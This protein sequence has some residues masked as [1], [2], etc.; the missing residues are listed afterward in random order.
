MP[1]R[2]TWPAGLV[3]GFAAVGAGCG[4]LW[5]WLW[6][7][8]G[9]VVANHVW[10]PDPWDQGQRADF[11]GTGLYVVIALAAG[12][13]LGGL[14]ASRARGRELVTLGAVTLGSVLAAVLMHVIGTQLAPGDPTRLARHLADGARLPGTLRLRGWASFGAFPVGALLPLAVVF[15]TTPGDGADDDSAAEEPAEH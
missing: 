11:T 2:L 3:A 13:L 8:P 6:D 1:Q 14:A 5:E 9:G 10:F 12:L 15:L 7:A 4:W